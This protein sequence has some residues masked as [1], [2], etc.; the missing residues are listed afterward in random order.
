LRQHLHL[1]AGQQEHAVRAAHRVDNRSKTLHL[2]P[3]EINQPGFYAL[4]LE[5]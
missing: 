5:A 1:I 2:S 3:V 4:T